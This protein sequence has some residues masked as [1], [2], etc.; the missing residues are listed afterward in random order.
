MNELEAK[1][2]LTKKGGANNSDHTYSRLLF[3]GCCTLPVLSFPLWI[4]WFLRC[5][6]LDFFVTL[7]IASRPVCISSPMSLSISYL[8]SSLNTNIPWGVKNIPLHSAPPFT[9]Y[10]IPS[11]TVPSECVLPSGGSSPATLYFS[12]Q[13]IYI[14]LS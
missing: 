9:S 6:L 1:C 2:Y 7:V 11:Q 12:P 8:F 10:A 3:L 5:I 4:C 14:S 13:F